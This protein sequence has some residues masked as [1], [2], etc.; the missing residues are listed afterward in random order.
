M[1]S[2]I[3]KTK[4]RIKKRSKS[5][6]TFNND[7]LKKTSHLKV[8]ISRKKVTN[9]KPNVTRS[10]ISQN[11]LPII[12]YYDITPP[13]LHNFY[14]N[15]VIDYI[16]IEGSVIY[17]TDLFKSVDQEL[18]TRKFNKIINKNTKTMN[19]YYG[20]LTEDIKICNSYN[21]SLQTIDKNTNR[22]YNY[23]GSIDCFFNGCSNKQIYLFN[24]DD[25]LYIC[26]STGEIQ[27]D[28]HNTNI[29]IMFNNNLIKNHIKS[30]KYN[31]IN[32]FGHSNG[33][34]AAQYTSFILFIN[35]DDDIYQYYEKRNYP[36]KK[37]SSLNSEWCKIILNKLIVCGSGG[38]PYLFTSESDFIKYYNSLGG[39]YIHIASNLKIRDKTIDNYVRS[40]YDENSNTIYKNYKYFVYGSDT[41]EEC[42]EYDGLF[43]ND[44]FITTNKNIKFI[45]DEIGD[46]A[47][48]FSIY[49][50]ILKN[51]FILKNE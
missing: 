24:R 37:I 13:H 32:L 1:S 12:P 39:R 47:H 25:E 7:K 27:P 44:N 51:F 9:R 14:K 23:L 31:K 43:I 16:G 41:V 42:T 46:L 38:Y 35:S 49:R 48:E 45:E 15:I 10:I 17:L 18:F 36:V 3:K 28:Q 20:D 6:I 19:S 50:K 40:Y 34:C 22:V 2:K 21:L 29:N 5:P 4:S 8:N 30:A 11:N 33:M 26:F